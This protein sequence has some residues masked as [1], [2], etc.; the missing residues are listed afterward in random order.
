M[1]CERGFLTKHTINGVI[2][3]KAADIAR[4]F[5]N[6]YQS[7]PEFKA[8]VDE[9]PVFPSF[10][11]DIMGDLG[12]ELIIKAIKKLTG[13]EVAEDIFNVFISGAQGNY[14]D[15]A[16]E[17]HNV[18]VD[19]A[20]QFNVAWKLYDFSSEIFQMFKKFRPL[21]A[22]LQEIATKVDAATFQK[23]YKAMS[24]I[25]SSNVLDKFQFLGEGIDKNL[26]FFGSAKDL[27]NKLAA[28]FGV[29]VTDL[30]PLEI[31]PLRKTFECVT[32]T[33]Q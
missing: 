11:F 30:T 16:Y 33:G 7:D 20:K 18:A 9:W 28:E 22:P 5:Q 8:M 26:K 15:M 19:V 23:I 27:M 17:L 24:K 4:S 2:E 6:T 10:L 12:K 1:L 29:S 32:K 25:T 14:L 3:Q 31:D 21:V 13:Y